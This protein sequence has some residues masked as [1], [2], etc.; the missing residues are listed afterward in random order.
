MN[1]KELI[2]KVLLFCTI[3][4][5]FLW[6]GGTIFRGVIAYRLFESFS[7]IVRSNLTTESIIQT[8]LIIGGVTVYI[9]SSYVLFLIFFY[10]FILT[11]KINLKNNGWLF[12]IVMIVTL[13][14]PVEVFTFIIDVKFVLLVYTPNFDPN[15]GLSL[16]IQRIAAL[17]GLPA[18]AIFSYF[19][20]IFLAILQ[21]LKRT[22]EVKG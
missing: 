11:S 3:I 15:L 5:G 14:I 12:M 2:Q 21:P 13:F 18:I 9:I 10:L 4:C 20:A 16:L 22:D 6:L 1:K 19:T 17:N 8:L 7:L